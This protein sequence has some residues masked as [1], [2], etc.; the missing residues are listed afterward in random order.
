MLLRGSKT[1]GDLDYAKVRAMAQEG[2][3]QDEGGYRAEMLGMIDKANLLSK[4]SV[5]AK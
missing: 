3:G 1:K 5:P 4:A 2:L